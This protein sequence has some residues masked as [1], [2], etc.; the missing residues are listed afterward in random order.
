M[1][2]SYQIGRDTAD[3]V[4]TRWF[5]K[6]DLRSFFVVIEKEIATHPAAG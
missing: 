1:S 2:S 4:M 5:G 3:V 6:A